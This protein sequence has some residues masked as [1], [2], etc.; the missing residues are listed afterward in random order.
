MRQALMELRLGLC[1]NTL[2]QYFLIT[3]S[4]SLLSLSLSLSLSQEMRQ[5]LKE[6]RLG[7][8]GALNISDKMEQMMNLMVQ[9]STLLCS[10][11]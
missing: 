11:A 1:L 6:L 8:D 3:L 5:T 7:L 2:S 10:T 9:P 4:F